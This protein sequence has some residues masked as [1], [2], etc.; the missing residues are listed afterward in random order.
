MKNETTGTDFELFCHTCREE[1]KAFGMGDWNVVFEHTTGYSPLA[2]IFIILEARSATISL[3]KDW[4]EWPVT[5]EGII[6]AARHEVLE[7]LL[8]ELGEL[9]NNYR[10][11]VSP[12]AMG[13]LIRSAKHGVISRIQGRFFPRECY[14]FVTMKLDGEIKTDPYTPRPPVKKNFKNKS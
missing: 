14:A 3:S 4:G 2:Y 6:N 11:N 8:G 9:Y 7:L 12:K 13:R 5:G 1:L 10:K